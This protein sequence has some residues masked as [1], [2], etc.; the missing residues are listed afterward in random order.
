M[1]I[2]EPDAARRA[3]S[4]ARLL[5]INIGLA[6]AGAFVAALLYVAIDTEPALLAVLWVPFLA[7]FGI[8]V[9]IFYSLPGVLVYVAVLAAV[10]RTWSPKRRRA[11]A[12]A[13]APLLIA[14]PFFTLGA[15]LSWTFRFCLVVGALAAAIFVRTEP[16]AE[17][18]RF[19]S[20]SP[21]R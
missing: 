2:G 20:A 21:A 18:P 10:P 4:R 17:R 6:Y 16:P 12:F 9:T 5:L 13:A 8:G 14:L 3:S 11:A 19:S 15:G 7:V 1:A